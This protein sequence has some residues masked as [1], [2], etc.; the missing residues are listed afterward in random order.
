MFAYF[1]H[2]VKVVTKEEFL[3]K[4][5]NLTPYDIVVLDESLFNPRMVA[6]LEQL[7]KQKAL[8]VIALNAL[9]QKQGIEQTGKPGTCF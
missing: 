5:H 9:L 2:D 4:K 7:K 1:R 3:G 6:Y 8:K